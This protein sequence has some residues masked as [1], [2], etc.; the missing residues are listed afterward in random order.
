MEVLCISIIRP[1]P[2]A[3]LV[4]KVHMVKDK[5]IAHTFDCHA[6]SELLLQSTLPVLQF[7]LTSAEDATDGKALHFYLLK[8]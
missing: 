6:L 7:Q 4:D 8:K 2:C 3:N 5:G 1:E